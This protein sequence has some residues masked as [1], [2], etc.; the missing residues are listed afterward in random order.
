MPF[1]EHIGV[2]VVILFWLEVMLI[3]LPSCKDL[4]AKKGR[5]GAGVDVMITIFGNFRRKNWRFS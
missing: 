1:I 4:V 5:K 2:V 3:H